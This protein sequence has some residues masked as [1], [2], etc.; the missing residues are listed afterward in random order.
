MLYSNN[1]RNK[2]EMIITCIDSVIRP[3]LFILYLYTNINKRNFLRGKV[4]FL[5]GGDSPRLLVFL[6]L[7]LIW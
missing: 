6:K 5:T 2:K 7:R 3:L 4:K 1:R